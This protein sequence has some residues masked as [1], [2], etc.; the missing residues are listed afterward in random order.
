[1]MLM[2]RIAVNILLFFLLLSGVSV[3]MAQGRLRMK[4]YGADQGLRSPGVN[5]L[6]QDRDG[7]VWVG[8]NMG[9]T[10][11]DGARFHTYVPH[12]GAYG[13]FGMQPRCLAADSL[14]R[15]W[16]GTKFG[17]FVFDIATSSFT[18]YE[19]RKLP[20]E[21]YYDAI[22]TDSIGRYVWTHCRG[23]VWRIDVLTDSV[24]AAEA[25]DATLPAWKQVPDKQLMDALDWR[26]YHRGA[27]S[28]LKDREGG[29]WIGSYYDG[30]FYLPPRQRTFLTID[31]EK[32][33]TPAIVRPIVQCSDG[34][35][36]VGTENKGLFQLIY[37]ESDLKLLP[38][39]INFEGR[40]LHANIQA[41]AAQG[42]SLWIGTFGEGIYL[43]NLRL[44][45][46]VTHCHL[47]HD[48]VVCLLLGADGSLLSGTMQGLYVCQKGQTE[49]LPV[50]GAEDGFIHALARTS[51]GTIW[52]GA[53][54]RPLRRITDAGGHSRAEA[55]IM[56]YPCVTALLATDDGRL[57]I[58]TDSKG[59]W[60]RNAGGDIVPT[61]LTGTVMESSVNTLVADREG[62]IWVGTFNGLFCYDP[63][64]QTVSRY[65]QANGLP[66]NFLSYGSGCLS[67]TDG[68][69][70]MGT[71]QGL[72]VFNASLFTLPSIP[73]KPFFTAV[74]IAGRDTTV[75]NALRLD[76]DDATVSI[77]YAV[78][79][80]AS[81][82]AVWYRY[83]LKGS[84]DDWTTGIAGQQ[85]IVLTHLAP[86]DYRLELQAS[87]TS[88]RW[89]GP[90]VGIDIT[91]TPPWWRTPWAF[92]L[93][94]MVVAAIVMLVFRVRIQRKERDD[95]HRQ[96]ASLMENREL[97]R[98]MPQLSPY[99]LIKHI[100]PA[101]PADDF[102]ER[103][104]AYLE[105]HVDDRQ[106]G[107]ESLATH[108]EVSTSTLYRRMKS[109]MSLSPVEYI[110]LY[111]LKKAAL[112]LRRDGL[113]IRQVSERLCFS[114]VAYFTNSFSSQFG[115]TPG[116]YQ[117]GDAK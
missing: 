104:D 11:F 110:R 13:A 4:H 12:F 102:M 6:A 83:R 86:G 97:M 78:P 68:Q 37:S 45:K 30:L 74:T 14:K 26:G 65:T 27:R 66:T 99:A 103:V 16:I 25:T 62:R 35:V 2:K 113:S 70:L 92:L 117:R 40:L 53:L 19:H 81:A 82:S 38:V 1:M 39:N 85:R 101:Q 18:R 10:R 51:D 3:V 88:S 80:Y 61:M 89:D 57:W 79:L 9:L 8:T 111:R 17:I 115:V 60:L 41:L 116:E 71:H 52:V 34:T 28:W 106:L 108:M 107:V 46:V 72:T 98:D 75:T 21:G 63:Q 112:M 5:C 29:V 94:I 64:Q 42:D 24:V 15:L 87:M 55:G 22:A 50:E 23:Q 93:Y 36:F 44:R 59:V 43:Y 109:T 91:V 100:V 76:Y 73:L 96:I 7:F 56:E 95:L 33:D 54:D 58:G 77:D 69:L 49:F 47:P 32:T 48:A 105:A 114:S 84:C 90:T 20:P 67:A 31:A